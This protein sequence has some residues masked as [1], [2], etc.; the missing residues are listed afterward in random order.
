[1]PYKT[2]FGRSKAGE[3]DAARVN[4]RNRPGGA[5]AAWSGIWCGVQQGIQA[6]TGWRCHSRA[7]AQP[8]TCRANVDR[9]AEHRCTPVTCRA[10]PP[11]PPSSGPCALRAAARASPSPPPGRRIRSRCRRT[12][13]RCARDAR[14]S[15]HCV[16]GRRATARCCYQRDDYSSSSSAFLE[17]SYAQLRIYHFNAAVPGFVSLL[18]PSTLELKLRGVPEDFFAVEPSCNPYSPTKCSRCMFSAR[19]LHFELLCPMIRTDTRMDIQSFN[20]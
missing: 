11:A 10:C 9:A 15:T 16:V 18:I 3:P 8:I 6:S 4:L 12:S 19:R 20:R 1:M 13:L 17:T 7:S 14:A 5:V 2:L